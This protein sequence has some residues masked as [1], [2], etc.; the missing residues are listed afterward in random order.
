MGENIGRGVASDAKPGLVGIRCRKESAPCAEAFRASRA[1][2]RA[3]GGASELDL[4][5]CRF[6]FLFR[7]CTVASKPL[8]VGGLV[9]AG[10][11]GAENILRPVLLVDLDLCKT[12]SFKRFAVKVGRASV[13]E[14][15][16][17]DA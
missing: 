9:D 16:E 4:E 13:S 17:L 6:V 8:V 5:L 15:P 10:D 3:A 12:R 1:F 7:L 2:C 14:M 11:T